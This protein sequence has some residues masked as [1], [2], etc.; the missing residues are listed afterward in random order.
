MIAANEWRMLSVHYSRAAPDISCP[1]ALAF[2][3]EQ[4]T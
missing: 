1:I 3:N 2:N 4:H